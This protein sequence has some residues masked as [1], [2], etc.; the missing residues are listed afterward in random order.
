MFYNVQEKDGEAMA[1]RM[2][3]TYNIA[4]YEKNWVHGSYY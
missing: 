3:M 2:N 1:C 4:S